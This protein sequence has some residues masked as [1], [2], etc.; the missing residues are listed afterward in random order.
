MKYKFL[1]N[2]KNNLRKYTEQP[3]IEIFDQVAI[4]PPDQKITPVVYQTWIINQFGRT[5][6]QEINKFRELNRNL[7]FKFFTDLQMDEYMKH[8]WGNHKIFEVY[9][10]S[11]I[12][13]LRTDI[14]RYC[15][16]YD[17]GGYYFDIS[18]GCKIPLTHL[19]KNNDEAVITFEDTYSFIPPEKKSLHLLKQPFNH[20]LQ[21][22][23]CFQK[24]H[25]ILEIL[26]EKI[27]DNYSFYKNKKFSNPKLA[28]LNFTGPGLYTKVV[29]NYIENYGLNNISQLDVKFNNNGIF[30]L[31]G[32]SFRYNLMPSYTYLEN[33]FI[34]K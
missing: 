25:K 32:S 20:F 5:H 24:N 26:I 15:I 34:C 33:E 11:L 6:A 4:D 22:G 14:F 18:R 16:L 13:P 17:R 2:L 19:H 9:Q 1:I 23:L 12:G 8:S 30:K 28:I 27:I 7:S 21:W 3:L 10:N 31:K 29:R